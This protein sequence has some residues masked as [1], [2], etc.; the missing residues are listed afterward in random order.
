MKKLFEKAGTFVV[1]RFSGRN[2]H[3]FT[4][5]D[6]I[7]TRPNMV[8]MAGIVLTTVYLAQYYYVFWL[9]LIPVLYPLVVVTDGLDGYLADKLD[10]NSKWGKIIDPIR[11]RYFTAV[12]LGNFW[13]VLG[14]SVLAPIVVLIEAELFLAVEYHITYRITGVVPNAHWVGKAR[15]AVQW[16]LG[17]VIVV[18]QYWLGEDYISPYLLIKIMAIT[19]VVA[20]LHYTLFRFPKL[21]FSKQ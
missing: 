3:S 10:E 7:L 17:Y 6:K 20:F 13:V 19:S 1:D 5:H 4:V 14:H 12:A 15:S 21:K 8:T 16:V 2:A 18:Q 9:A 11:D